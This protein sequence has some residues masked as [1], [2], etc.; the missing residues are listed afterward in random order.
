MADPYQNRTRPAFEKLL[1]GPTM[2]FGEMVTG[3]HYLEV[4]QIGKQMA[5]GPSAPSY[6]SL[7][8][9]FVQES[10]FVGAI[11]RGFRPWGL[12]QCAKGIPVLFV[13]H[14]SL[15]Q[16]HYRAGWSFDRAEVVSGF[17]GGAAQGVLVNP[18]QKVKVAVI[19]S[20]HMNSLSPLQAVRA[21]VQQEGS[22]SLFD[23][24]VPMVLRRSLD[25]GIRFGVSNNIKYL[26]EEQK[27]DRGQ[28]SDLSFAELVGCGIVGGVAGTLTHPIDNMITASQK[29]LPLGA[30]KDLISVMRR[31]YQESGIKAFTRSWAIR[32]V[33]NVSRPAQVLFTPSLISPILTLGL[34]YGVDVW[35]RHSRLCMG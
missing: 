21:I 1:I 5:V 31:M 35:R 10:G 17:L 14:E 6:W 27:H 12:I 11:Y 34:P 25:W 23:G 33:D 4:L 24:V 20:E 2:V 3:G 22:L 15:Y 29:P 7:H 32:V 9:Q 18:F 16:L 30:K 19:A 26:V 8:S 28:S 13:Q